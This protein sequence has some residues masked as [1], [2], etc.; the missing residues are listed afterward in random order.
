MLFDKMTFAKQVSTKHLEEIV[1]IPL[2][3]NN[4]VNI[5][6][7]DEGVAKSQQKETVVGVIDKENISIRPTRVF[8]PPLGPPPLGR[9]QS[10][11]PTAVALI[12]SQAASSPS[13]VAETFYSSDGL[14]TFPS[15]SLFEASS[16][17]EEQRN[18][19]FFAESREFSSYDREEGG[20]AGDREGAA[21]TAGSEK[22][23]P[24]L[25]TRVELPQPYRTQ[26]RAM[27][28]LVAST[29][30]WDDAVARSISLFDDDEDDEYNSGS[31]GDD[32]YDNDIS[33]RGKEANLT[34]PLPKSG[35]G[36]SLPTS[37]E[38][39]HILGSTSSISVSSLDA[40]LVSADNS[41]THHVCSSCLTCAFF[42]LA[43]LVLLL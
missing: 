33:V 2:Y 1:S 37:S 40:I 5:D 31:E 32:E 29:D 27:M 6:R 22:D 20:D 17:E 30:S 12:L 11:P 7:K 34:L 42:V 10:K 16:S 18:R 21:T 38:Q 39:V 14:P 13:T 41:M 26:D 9:T 25:R 8:K 35:A 4:K 23:P 3:E 28:L 43:R 15:N 19:H 24:F 36:V